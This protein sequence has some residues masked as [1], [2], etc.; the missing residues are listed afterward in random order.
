MYI[1]LHSIALNGNRFSD[2]VKTY[3]YAI[4]I[5]MFYEQELF[6]LKWKSIFIL[7]LWHFSGGLCPQSLSLTST[8]GDSHTDSLNP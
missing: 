6:I 7:F 1:Q 8:G 5:A 3:L 4:T 2:Y